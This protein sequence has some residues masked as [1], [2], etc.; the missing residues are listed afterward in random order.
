MTKLNKDQYTP[1]PWFIGFYDGSGRGEGDDGIYITPKI[2]YDGMDIK[3]EDDCIVSGACACC[4]CGVEQG[5]LRMADARLIAAAP[6]LYEAAQWVLHVMNG[7]GKAGGE[8][9]PGEHEAALDAL[10]AAAKKTEEN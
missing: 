8:P 7:V 9:E 6:D 5:V 10:M 1:A 2:V 4:S 3:E